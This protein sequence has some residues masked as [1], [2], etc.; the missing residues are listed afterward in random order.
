M[1]T[2]PRL[3]QA[4]ESGRTVTTHGTTR[5][6][7]VFLDTGSPTTGLRAYPPGRGTVGRKPR[8]R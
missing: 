4:G 1:T 7:T 3:G 5:L 8:E 2:L 6:E